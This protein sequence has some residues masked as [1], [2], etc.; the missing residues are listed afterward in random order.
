MLH[1]RETITL[2]DSRRW[3][4]SEP[5]KVFD[6]VALRPGGGVGERRPAVQEVQRIPIG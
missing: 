6:A 2:E 1:L 4:L 3:T 5:R